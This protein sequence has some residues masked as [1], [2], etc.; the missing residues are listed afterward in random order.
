[1]LIF[2]LIARQADRARELH[3]PVVG[4]Q[5]APALAA[6]LERNQAMLSAG[7]DD[8]EAKIRAGELDV[9]LTVDEKFAADVAQGR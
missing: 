8:Y 9:V 2:N 1:M 4:V 3:L 5:H 6:F 7:T